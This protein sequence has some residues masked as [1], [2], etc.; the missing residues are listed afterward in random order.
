MPV[1]RVKLGGRNGIGRK[2]SVVRSRLQRVSRLVG[3]LKTGF[4][5]RHSSGTL[6]SAKAFAARFI[7]V[8][9]RPLC[10]PV[11]KLTRSNVRKGALRRGAQ[12]KQDRKF[13]KRV[14]RAPRS[15]KQSPPMK[16]AASVI[17]LY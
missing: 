13:Q 3:T 11:H 1:V 14:A 6:E 15:R 8:H 5:S 7:K 4:A 12:L 2:F 9:I 10:K 17:C 16:P